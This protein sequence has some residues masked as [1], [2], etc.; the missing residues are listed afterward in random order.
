M[1]AVT[2]DPRHFASVYNTARTVERLGG[3]WAPAPDY[4][5]SIV[6]DYLNPL[7]GS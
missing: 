5:I 4:G 6:N 2:P 3:A 7:L 1:Q